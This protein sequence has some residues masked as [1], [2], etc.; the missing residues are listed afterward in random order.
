MLAGM[1]TGLRKGPMATPACCNA[2]DTK[3]AAFPS[4][5]IAT[6]CLTPPKYLVCFRGAYTSIHK[7]SET[8]G[9]SQA[10][11]SVR[12]VAC[13]NLGR[14]EVLDLAQ[15]CS[16]EHSFKGA[17]IEEQSKRLAGSGDSAGE[18]VHG[19]LLFRIQ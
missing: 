10:V 11:S 4:I 1:I 16:F 9:D 18:R 15:S 8:G 6:V 17:R 19:Q 2:P 7:M 3:S 14:S 5:R 13:I 12:E